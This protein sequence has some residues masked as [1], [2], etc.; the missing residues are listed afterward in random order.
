MSMMHLLVMDAKMVAIRVVKD[1]T[2]VTKNTTDMAIVD[3]MYL[4]VVDATMVTI[5]VVKD[6]TMVAITVVMDA[7]MVEHDTWRAHGCRR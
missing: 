4:L 3:M 7:T 1:A 6:A 2:M 5:R